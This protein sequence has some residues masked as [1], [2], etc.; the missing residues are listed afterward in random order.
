MSFDIYEN[1]L[2]YRKYR[3][4]GKEYD[5]KLK[6][7]GYNLEDRDTLEYRL[8]EYNKETNQNFHL[9]L[10][11][12]GLKEI[13][14]NLPEFVR[15][16]YLENN[17]IKKIENLEKLK[18]LE[19]IDLSCNYLS[20]IDGLVD[21]NEIS[22]KNNKISD[23]DLLKNFT[24]L[25]ILDISYNKIKSLPKMQN[26][27]QIECRENLL[28]EIPSLKNVK[29]IYAKKNKI[30]KL[31]NLKSL[32]L[33]EIDDNLLEEITTC[34]NIEELYILN[35]KIKRL[36]NMNCVKII[37]CSGNRLTKLEYFPNIK[38]LTMDYDKDIEVD[39]KY[40]LKSKKTELFKNSVCRFEF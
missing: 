39:E 30:N 2:K 23:I 16:L 14:K 20:S 18:Y 8:K 31:G 21:A 15:H 35:N 26:V 10:S 7:K 37:Q 25:R 9:D 38:E 3:N 5:D 28:T 29:V 4:L 33:L 40:A 6:S 12:L 34:P 27:E 24:K 11:H 1:D 19:T 36:S 13:P 22:I 32:K 17:K